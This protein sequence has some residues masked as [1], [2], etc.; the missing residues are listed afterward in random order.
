MS[1]IS[2]LVVAHSTPP[3]SNGAT[4][5]QDTGTAKESPGPTC[6]ARPGY[7]PNLELSLGGF[8]GGLGSMRCATN[9]LWAMLVFSS[10]PVEWCTACGGRWDGEK[11]G[12]VESPGE[13]LQARKG[14]GVVTLTVGNAMASGTWEQ[15]VQPA[16][17][18]RCR[19]APFLNLLQAYHSRHHG[20][21]WGVIVLVGGLIC[22]ET[23]DD[24]CHLQE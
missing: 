13:V 14:G 1:P 22:E 10:G 9:W 21:L 11:R 3:V 24:C 4:P 6:Q 5:L 16:V 2:P 20:R 19:I 12:S 23:R 15:D 7:V 8:T 17:K 18:E